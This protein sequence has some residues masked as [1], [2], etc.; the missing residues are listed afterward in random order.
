MLK[1]L[2]TG[3]NGQLGSAI[4]NLSGFYRDIE[5]IF[6]DLPELDITNE[7]QC[8]RFIE[9]SA[10]SYIVNCAA[11]TAV[12]DA[13]I[14]KDSAYLINSEAVKILSESALRNNIRMI[15]I[16]T[17]YVFEGTNYRPYTEKDPAN[18]QTVY[19]LSKLEGERHLYNKDNSVIIRTSWLYSGMEQSFV[20]KILKAATHNP[21]IKVIYDQTGSPTYVN[22][23][24]SAILQIISGIEKKEKDF[25]PGIFHYSNEGIASWYDFAMD[26]INSQNINCN[27]IPVESEEFPTRARRP[28]YSVLSKKK[29]KE[30]YGIGIAHWRESLKTLLNTIK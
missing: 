23:L 22:D 8:R 7:K 17:D 14:Q 11:Y 18:P 13:E 19:G 21:E 25:V 16:S 3:A 26:I 12:D 29:I 10:C 5:F 2:I 24:A 9:N 6:T 30:I 4:K 15:H 27:I 28:H 20:R 1:I